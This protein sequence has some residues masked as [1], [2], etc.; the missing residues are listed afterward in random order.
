M[1]IFI[2]M[3]ELLLALIAAVAPA[4]AIGVFLLQVAG[5]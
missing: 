5:K 1:R 4:V 3:I 2:L